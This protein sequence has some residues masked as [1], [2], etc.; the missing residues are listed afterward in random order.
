LR[1]RIGIKT[2]GRF[3]LVDPRE[4][5]AVEA[6]GNYVCLCLEGRVHLLRGSISSMAEQLRPYGFVRVHRSTLVNGAFVT[7]IEPYRTG[8][9]GVHL[10]GGKEYLVTRKYKG[11]L[12]SVASCWIG[13]GRSPVVRKRK[14]EGRVALRSPRASPLAES[15]PRTEPPGPSDGLFAAGHARR[16]RP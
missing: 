5:F 14:P 4:V 7:E 6:Q 11:N 12:L 15:H 9:Y 10:Q 8:E 13:A 1:Q 2:G 16:S 3:V